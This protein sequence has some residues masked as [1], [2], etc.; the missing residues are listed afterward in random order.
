MTEEVRIIRAAD[1]VVRDRGGGVRTTHLVTAA[2]ARETPFVNGVTEF[3]PGAALDFHYHDCPESV[4][5]LEG[6]ARFELE[7]GSH[8]MEAGDATFVPAGVPHRF[9]NTG[10]DRMRLF[11]VYGSSSP[12]RTMVASGKTFPIGSPDDVLGS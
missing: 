11:F 7:D 4:L 6:R 2:S 10:D 3:D 8:P 5:V 12:T 9:V 1:V